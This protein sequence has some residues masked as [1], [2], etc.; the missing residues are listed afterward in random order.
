MTLIH[1]LL[2]RLA[3]RPSPR[4]RRLPAWQ[5]GALVLLSLGAAG[6][7]MAGCNYT[8]GSGPQT[9]GPHL[10]GALPARLDMRQATIGANLAWAEREAPRRTTWNCT[11]TITYSAKVTSTSLTPLDASKGTYESGIPGVGIRFAMNG[12]SNWGDARSVPFSSNFTAGWNGNYIGLPNYVQVIFFRTGAGVG[13]GQVKPFDVDIMFTI[14][15][16]PVTEVTMRGSGFT[17]YLDQNFYYTS[18]H[19]VTADPIVPM[20]RPTIATVKQNKAP[21]QPFALDIKCEGMNPLTK[22][23]VKIYFEGTS[24]G[25]G[26]LSVD[27]AGQAGVA[28]GVEIALTASDGKTPLPFTQAGA[29]RLA[30]T[31]TAINAETYRFAGNAQ[32]VPGTEEGKAGKADATLSYILEYN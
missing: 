23:P 32:Y 22:P 9:P 1:A 15:T 2:H 18:C 12:Y 11:G 19:N 21:V 27:N 26:R 16:N 5:A 31:G 25:A 3:T 4:G 13:R 24:P 7:A 30:H 10:Y 14:N 8:S 20:G 29:L 17:T 6:N 28:K